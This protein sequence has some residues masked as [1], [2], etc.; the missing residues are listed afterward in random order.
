MVNKWDEVE[1]ALGSLTYHKNSFGNC[2]PKRLLVGAIVASVAHSLGGD[3]GRVVEAIGVSRASGRLLV[4]L[5]NNSVGNSHLIADVS[6]EVRVIEGVDS[7][8]EAVR[9]LAGGRCHGRA[10]S[11]WSDGWGRV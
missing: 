11:N 8:A 7:A 10:G 4:G 3:D 6:R 5:D 2:H 9:T 1:W